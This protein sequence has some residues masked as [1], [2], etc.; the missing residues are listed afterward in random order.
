MR[1]PFAHLNLRRNPFGELPLAD[2]GKIAVPSIN[3]KSIIAQLEKPRFAVQFL[4]DKGRG[5]TTHLLA[6]RVHF[7]EAPYIH[8]G[9]QEP[10]PRIPRVPLVFLDEMQRIP[11]RQRKRL[12]KWNT[13]WVIGTHEDHQVEMERAGLEVYMH[14]FCGLDVEQLVTLANRRISMVVRDVEQPVPVLDVSAAQRLIR[15]YSDD[16]RAIE[17]HLYDVFQNMREV[18]YV[19][20]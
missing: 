6:L 18:G 5:K 17:G 14:R 15:L 20:V 7:P 3:L 16:V 9:E 13:S 4:G 10:V 11:P 19:K 8:I 2:R 1:L 12:F